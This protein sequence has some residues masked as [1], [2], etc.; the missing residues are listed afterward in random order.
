LVV[1]QHDLAAERSRVLHLAVAERLRAEPGLV[2]VA[3]K[4]TSGWLRDGSVNAWYAS[5][6]AT[7]LRKPIAELVE[8]LGERSERMHDLRQTSPFAGFIDARTRWRILGEV[9]RKHE[10]R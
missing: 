9:R 7:L 2:D 10:T 5:Q 3:R 6:W 1:D 4:R 8:I